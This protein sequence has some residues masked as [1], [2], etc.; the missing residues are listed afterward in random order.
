MMILLG[1]QFFL[2]VDFVLSYMWD[3]LATVVTVFTWSSKELHVKR[4]TVYWRLFF[5]LFLYEL[6]SDQTLWCFFCWTTHSLLRT[7]HKQDYFT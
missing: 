3:C 6:D 4:V 5:F 7:M 2:L 1:T